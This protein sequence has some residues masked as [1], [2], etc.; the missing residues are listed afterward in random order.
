MRL[1]T[2]VLPKIV[3]SALSYHISL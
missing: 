2:D 3:A 1:L